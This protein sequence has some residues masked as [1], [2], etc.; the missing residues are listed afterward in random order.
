M[1]RICTLNNN[2]L[3]QNMIAI[4]YQIYLM[5][6]EIQVLELNTLILQHWVQFTKCRC[7]VCH[8][9]LQSCLCTNI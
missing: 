2:P 5:I 9:N 8:A 4:L 1:I 3:I 7:R 6:K